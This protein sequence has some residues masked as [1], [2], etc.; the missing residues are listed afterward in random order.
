MIIIKSITR[1]QLP[2]LTE[3]IVLLIHVQLTPQTYYMKLSLP[4]N[5]LIQVTFD[6]F[7]SQKVGTEMGSSTRK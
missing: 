5:L 4:K 2:F 1:V 3:S 6:N 7:K